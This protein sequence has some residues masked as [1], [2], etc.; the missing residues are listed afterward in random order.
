MNVAGRAGGPGPGIVRARERG[1]AREQGVAWNVVGPPIS[2]IFEKP[3]KP[4]PNHFGTFGWGPEAERDVYRHM[5]V[6]SV[7]RCIFLCHFIYIK[8]KQNKYYH[9]SILSN[10]ISYDMFLILVLMNHELKTVLT[11]CTA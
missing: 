8:H 11:M 2:M 5:H 6:C 10:V 9:E 1:G 4:R 7:Y 3:S